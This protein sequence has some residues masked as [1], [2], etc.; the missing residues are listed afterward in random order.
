MSI[1][2]TLLL[3]RR[4]AA[5]AQIEQAIRL[6]HEGNLASAITLAGAAEGCLSPNVDAKAEF[7]LFELLKEAH[8]ER[9]GLSERKAVTQ[10]NLAR[11]F[12]KHFDETQPPDTRI[13]LE[14]LDAW[15]MVVRATSKLQAIDSNALTPVM[16][17]FYAYSAKYASEIVSDAK[18]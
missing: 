15:I 10:L 9:R 6:F 7:F 18:R 2:P 12:L 8:A 1:P 3:T 14:A 13:R 5:I 11:D 17:A 16:K 4:Q